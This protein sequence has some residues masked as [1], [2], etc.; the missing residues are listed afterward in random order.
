MVWALVLLSG[1]GFVR[2]CE[3]G[4]HPITFV[5]IKDQ[6]KDD[7]NAPAKLDRKKLEA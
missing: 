3:D 5:D 7:A 6:T 2:G 4:R 1:C